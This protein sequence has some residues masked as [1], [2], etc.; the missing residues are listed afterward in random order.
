MM[1][2][3]FTPLSL[4]L[5]MAWGVLFLVSQPLTAS[6]DTTPIVLYDGALGGTPDTQGWSYLTNPPFQP[7]S[8]TQT[9][10][11]GVTILD[12]TPNQSEAAG[13]FNSAHTLN[14]A[15]G[16]ALTFVT[17]VITESHANN[18]RAGFSVIVLSSDKK[19]IELGFWTDRIW[20]QEGG[21]PP[22]FTQ[23]EGVTLPTTSLMTYTLTISGDT[24]TLAT[25]GSD[26][27]TGPVRDYSSAN[28]NFNPYT[29]PN[30]IFFGDDT[31]SAQAMI[32]LKAVTLRSPL[33][34]VFLPIVMR[35]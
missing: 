35:N 20:A 22:S 28:V 2:F 3:I 15:T 31:S 21:D 34:Q 24:Y 19:G 9:Y 6:A 1:R 14:R 12:T 7:I 25:N 16:Y 5:L 26:V 8:A 33:F 32:T 13:Y 29:I 23:A 17:E 27:L 10:S 4:G 30:L 11:D 18:N